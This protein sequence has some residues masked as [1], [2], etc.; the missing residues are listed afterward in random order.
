MAAAAHLHATWYM[1]YS[2]QGTSEG[3]CACFTFGSDKQAFN[4]PRHGQFEVAHP[5][6]QIG[7]AFSKSMHRRRQFGEVSMQSRRD[8]DDP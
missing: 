4:P 1:D 6:V 3:R 5:G 8:P 7:I 2:N